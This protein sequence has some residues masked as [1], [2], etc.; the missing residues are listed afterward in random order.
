MLFDLDGTLFDYEASEAAAVAATL[1]EAGT[2][3]TDEVVALYREV[4][5][6]HWRA[7]ERGE[8]TAAELR[9]ARW[10]EVFETVGSAPTLDVAALAERYLE[11]LA[12]GT[13]LVADAE[14]VLE[15][16]SATHAIAFITNGLADVQRPRLASSPVGRF[17]EVVVI[18]DE[19]GA[20]K[21]DGAIFDAAFA[22]MGS[23]PRD[24]V[25]LVGD[26]VT[27][28]VAGGIAYGLT[29]VWFDPAGLG[30]VPDGG[31]QPTHRISRLRE[32]PPLLRR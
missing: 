23:P 25:V 20:A 24:D 6:R 1:E 26:S 14:A 18:S 29:T 7:L 21:P 3:S 11:H 22:A 30:P 2:P 16:L 5:A 17:A 10:A 15:E 12:A 9:L 13:H 4:N 19:V 32:L 8:T 27:A 31:P 28:D